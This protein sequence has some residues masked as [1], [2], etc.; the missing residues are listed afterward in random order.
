[1]Y[2]KQLKATRVTSNKA[3]NLEPGNT[4]KEG[5]MPKLTSTNEGLTKIAS[6]REKE[7]ESR[8]ERRTKSIANPSKHGHKR[9]LQETDD[10]KDRHKEEK[11]PKRNMVHGEDEGKIGKSSEIPHSTQKNEDNGERELE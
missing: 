3:K 9:N 8:H 6:D 2:R 10:N 11:R 7:E 5:R 4:G 1:M